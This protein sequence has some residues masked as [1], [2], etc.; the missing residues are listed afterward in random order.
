MDTWIKISS[1]ENATTLSER[2][3][4][5]GLPP[6]VR[7]PENATT[8]YSEQA[9]HPGGP[10]HP[11]L[12]GEVRLAMFD[13]P[14]YVHPDAD[15]HELDPLIQ[16]FVDAGLVPEQDLIDVQNVIVNNRGSHINILDIIPDY[17]ELDA[18]T[19]Q[20]MEDLGFYQEAQQ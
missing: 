5:L 16:P 13:T 20:Q 10:I 6:S 14:F 9:V 3:W 12:E 15:E 7:P 18:L 2:I 19:N 1:N 17:W 4:N 11:E 8:K